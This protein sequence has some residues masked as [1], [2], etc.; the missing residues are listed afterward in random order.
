MADFP[1]IITDVGIVERARL[2]ALGMDPA[3]VRMEIGIGQY[4]PDGT[5]TALM[6]PFAPVREFSTDFTAHVVGTGIIEIGWQDPSDDV[7]NIGEVGFYLFTGV[8]FAIASQPA[9]MGFLDVKTVGGTF[10]I[11]NLIFDNQDLTSV[12]FPQSSTA[13]IHATTTATGI[14]RLG[15][16]AENRDRDNE[17]QSATPKGVH[18]AVWSPPFAS[19]VEDLNDY[20]TPGIFALEDVDTI[21]NSPVQTTGGQV[22]VVKVY[23]LN[24]T[25]PQSNLMQEYIIGYPEDEASRWERFRLSGMW[26]NWYRL[27]RPAAS[28]NQAMASIANLVNT[29]WMTPM[30]VWQLIVARMADSGDMVSNTINSTGIVTP[31]RVKDYVNNRFVISDDAPNASDGVD[32]D[33][34][35]EY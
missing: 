25:S 24:G 30:R 35:F 4:T 13:V 19:A 27:D 11:A 22:G 12:M 29:V 21:A 32:G 9:A 5:E 33:V 3:I 23:P 10:F 28:L 34:W 18:G 14:V 31:V 15:T 8:L 1:A 26:T 16:E 20:T 7:Y 2:V 6:T 17:A